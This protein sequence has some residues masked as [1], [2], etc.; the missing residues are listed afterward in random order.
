MTR[1]AALG[2]LLGL[3]ALAA[4]PMQQSGGST[5]VGGPGGSTGGGGDNANV[6]PNAMITMPD[7]NGRTRD[8][9][10]AMVRAAGFKHEAEVQ[11]I[12]CNGPEQE[13]GKVD[14]Q[15]PDPGKSVQAYTL[16]RFNVKEGNRLAAG[17]VLRSDFEKMQG[18]TVA[19]AKGYAKTIGHTGELQ[20]KELTDFQTG[21][22]DGTVCKAAHAF[23][24][25]SGMSK[26]DIM[27][28]WT[29]KTLSIAPPPD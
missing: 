10:I 11:P 28:L 29:N 15:D 2:A 26:T 25:Q 3:L 7:L 17:N 23:G 16:V 1:L 4:C 14:C 6:S 8:E 22:K 13:V 9:A 21:C 19:D 20:V 24:S 18:M 5:M 27:I 12:A